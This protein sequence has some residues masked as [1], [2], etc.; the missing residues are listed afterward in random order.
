NAPLV[1][2][3]SLIFPY[4]DGLF[5]VGALKEKGGW[6]A[7]D[8]VYDDPPMS[9]EQIIHPEKYLDRDDPVAVRFDLPRPLLSWRNIYDDVS[10]ELGA[11]L[12]LKQ[13]L[14]TL[15]GDRTLAAPAT[16]GWDGDRSLLLEHEDGQLLYLSLS[17]WDSESD[18]EE[19]Y[20]ATREVTSLRFPLAPT[21]P[22]RGTD[23]EAMQWTREHELVFVERRGVDVLYVEGLP[24]DTDLSLD[25]LRDTIWVTRSTEP[26]PTY[27]ESVQEWREKEAE[28]AAA[29]DE[30]T[31]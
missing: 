26:Y 19:F 25:T 31:P 24:A 22:A 27:T 6:E 30:E 13:H 8:A 14:I 17:T 18:A 11:Y 7:V 21:I 10:G 4:I 16:T 29:A 23:S 1:V 15:D 12:I 5:F 20:D 2:R 28:K 3:E 9:T